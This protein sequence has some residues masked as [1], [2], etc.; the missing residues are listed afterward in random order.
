[1]Y[2]DLHELMLRNANLP[3][4]PLGDVRVAAA[5]RQLDEATRTLANGSLSPDTNLTKLIDEV[6]A[7]PQLLDWELTIVITRSRSEPSVDQGDSNFTQADCAD[8]RCFMIT[9][10]K[11]LFVPPISTR[12]TA[13]T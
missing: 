3:W 8:A 1:M 4:R 13:M 9:P 7:A 12:P 5:N 11:K 6:T 10:P 2:L